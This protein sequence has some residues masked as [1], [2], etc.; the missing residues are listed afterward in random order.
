[1]EKLAWVIKEKFFKVN[2]S[3]SRLMHINNTMSINLTY[4]E[5]HLRDF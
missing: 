3:S 4:P 5:N 2:V 1:M